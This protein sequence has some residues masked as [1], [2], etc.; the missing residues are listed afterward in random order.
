MIDA[1]FIIAQD[2]DIMEMLHRFPKIYPSPWLEFLLTHSYHIEAELLQHGDAVDVYKCKFHLKD[3]FE[4]LYY[5]K[6]R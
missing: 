4:S 3:N 1:E 2:D 6:Y 5:L